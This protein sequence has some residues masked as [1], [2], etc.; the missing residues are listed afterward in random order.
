ML[1]AWPGLS[2]HPVLADVTRPR[3]MRELFDRTCP[4]AVFHAAAY[5]HVAMMERDVLSAVRANVLGSL[6]VAKLAAE[7]GARFLLISSDKAANARSVMG[8]SKRL[9][10][11]AVLADSGHFG[12]GRHR[13][14]RQRPREQR[15]R[16]RSHARA[17]PARPAGAGRPIRSRPDIS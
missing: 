5:K 17:D 3:Q 6:T 12:A 8:A 14:I 9:A 10:E 2:L 15:Q 4:T 16:R 11:L 1:E 7:H 13:T